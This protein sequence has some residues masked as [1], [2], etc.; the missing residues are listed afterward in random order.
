MTG[1][2]SANY[3]SEIEVA[4]EFV[5]KMGW[6]ELAEGDWRNASVE[7]TDTSHGHLLEGED[8]RDEVLMVSFESQENLMNGV[9]SIFVDLDEKAVIGYVPT[10]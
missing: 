2:D 8:E 10:E 9:P 7:V 6:D 4:W 5:K 1:E 3:Q